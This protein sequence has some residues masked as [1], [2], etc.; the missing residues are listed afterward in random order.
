MLASSSHIPT[1]SVYIEIMIFLSHGES[2]DLITC[3]QLIFFL[4]S[5]SYLLT[6]FTVSYFLGKVNPIS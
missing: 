4:A 3:T 2:H 1:Y 6:H 5:A